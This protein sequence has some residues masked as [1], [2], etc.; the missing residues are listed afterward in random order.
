MTTRSTPQWR[1]PLLAWIPVSIAITAEATSN[2]L[3]AYGLGAHLEAFT[4]TYAGLTI[5]L[6]GA[7]LV[8]AAIAIS[9]SQTRAAWVALTPGEPR[10]RIIAGLA[11]CLLLSIS[12]TAMASHI[13]EAQRAKTGAETQDTTA[14]TNAK[15]LYDAKAADYER[16]KGSLSLAEVEAQIETAGQQIDANIWRRS[17]KCTDVTKRASQEECRTVT[18][19]FAKRAAARLK[20]ELA[21]A[22]PGLKAEMERHKLKGEATTS[23]ASVSWAWAWIMGL[24]VV[25]IATFGPA[26]FARVEQ[27]D[28]TVATAEDTFAAARAAALANV[29]SSPLAA[30]FSG[31]QP[32]RLPENEPPQPPK[33]GGK[34]KTTQAPANVAS[35]ANVVTFPAGGKHPVVAAL[36]SVGG[37]VASNR[38]LANLMGVTDG[39]AT[40]RRQEVEHL[41]HVEH[42]GKARRIAL[43]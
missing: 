15:A 27:H 30:M 6:A 28:V 11:A 9:L 22:L 24:G 41:L 2:A 1:I 16:V 21:A 13:L 40:K 42:A 18:A 32:E 14:Y 10:Q 25:L 34:R 3:R 29:T 12:I 35:S 33:G 26:I 38:E 8:L 4:V 31:E 17:A 23:E 36:E 5:S 37:S 19:L 43:R 39:E 7:V 20:D